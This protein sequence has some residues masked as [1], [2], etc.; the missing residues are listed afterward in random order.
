[1]TTPSPM[2]SSRIAEHDKRAE[3][4]DHQRRDLGGEPLAVLAHARGGEIAHHDEGAD[5]DERRRQDPGRRQAAGEKAGSR[6]E[7][8]E[9]GE[10][11]QARDMLGLMLL[12]LALLAL[13]ADE[14]AEQDGDGEIAGNREQLL[15]FHRLQFSWRQY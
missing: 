13:D 4:E 5:D 15:L 10:G 11:A 3:Q 7:Q 8:R 12:G 1:M 14:S 6:A 9:Q 2:A